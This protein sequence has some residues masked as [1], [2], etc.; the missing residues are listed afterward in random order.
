METMRLALTEQ[1]ETQEQME[2]VL[3][4]KLKENQELSAGEKQTDKPK[5][6]N[7]GHMSYLC[8]GPQNMKGQN[9]K[10]KQFCPYSLHCAKNE[11]STQSWAWECLRYYH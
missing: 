5:L 2:Q 3:E 6:H 4:E 11:S 7:K 1:E 10:V 9:V 8:K